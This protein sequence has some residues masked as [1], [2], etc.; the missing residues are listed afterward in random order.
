MKR[1]YFL[2]A[3]LSAVLL[4]C[5]C[6]NN[7]LAEYGTLHEICENAD[8]AL[9]E[10]Y[11]NLTMP[12]RITF[13]EP[14]ALCEFRT[15]TYQSD[16]TGTDR[17]QA[18]LE[19]MT[20][21]FDAQYLQTWQE[22]EELDPY[23]FQYYESDSVYARVS[24]EGTELQYS[25]KTAGSGYYFK[26]EQLAVWHIDRGDVDADTACEWNG[27]TYAVSALLAGADNA[28]QEKISPYLAC[29]AVRAKTAGLYRMKDGSEQFAVEYE[30]T[31]HGVAIDNSSDMHMVGSEEGAE[32]AMLSPVLQVALAAPDK[33]CRVRADYMLPT[34]T[35][36]QLSD[37][38]VT[39]RSALRIVEDYL[40]PE[41]TY[42]VDS[43]E[44]VYAVICRA[45]DTGGYLCRPY[46]RFGLN[47]TQ[48]N[49]QMTDGIFVYVDMQSGAVIVN[50]V[51]GKKLDDFSQIAE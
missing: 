17:L 26:G 11:Q 4:L 35:P 7:S 9:H 23:A 22:G 37:H 39:L 40:A 30:C 24:Q 25:D 44:P 5:G 8:S 6:T 21:T 46:W 36:K 45:G 34:D 50:D 20:G 28:V 13:P 47:E 48:G 16:K 49:I 41:H 10:S 2:P 1:R 15:L 18:F 12:E 29:E 38:F 14:T 42:R 43:I 31:M 27:V 33:I 3:A 51:L 19:G 32:Y